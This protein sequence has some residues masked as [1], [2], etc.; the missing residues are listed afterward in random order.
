MEGKRLAGEKED[1]GAEGD[2]EENGP[3]QTM[4]GRGEYSAWLLGDR[5]PCPQRFIYSPHF[6]V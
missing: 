4:E 5:R 2:G 3:G 1:I 6:S